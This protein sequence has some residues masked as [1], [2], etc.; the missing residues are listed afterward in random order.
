MKQYIDITEDIN[1]NHWFPFF[2]LVR[3]LTFSS[4]ESIQILKNLDFPVYNWQVLYIKSHRL[5]I[6]G[7]N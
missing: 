7:V 1:G 3:K 6:E 5:N 2:E 4:P